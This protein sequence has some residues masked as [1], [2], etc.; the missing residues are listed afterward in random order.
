MSVGD[1]CDQSMG[2]EQPQAASECCGLTTQPLEI[3]G[4]LMKY[5]AQVPVT[6]AVQGKLP[7]VNDGQELGV[8]LSKG[9]K[10][11]MAAAV[12]PH[13]ATYNCRFF[14]QRPGNMDCCQRGQITVVG[15]PADLSSPVQIGHA[16]PQDGPLHLSRGV[17]FRT[18]PDPKVNCALAHTQRGVPE[19]WKPPA[20]LNYPKPFGCGYAALRSIR[21]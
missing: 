5:G 9:I 3:L 11:A 19:L 4:G 18:V 14:G 15:R 1:F 17:G 7:A 10:G 21:G 16:A 6:K 13:W 8:R 2:S 20:R 12:S